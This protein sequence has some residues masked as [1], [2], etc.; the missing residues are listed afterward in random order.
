MRPRQSNDLGLVEGAD[1]ADGLL[2]VGINTIQ[3]DEVLPPIA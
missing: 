3:I 1:V 2:D